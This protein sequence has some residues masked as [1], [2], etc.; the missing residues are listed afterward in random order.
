MRNIMVEKSYTKC[1][2]E[3]F[4]RLLPKKPKLNILLNQ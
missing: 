4:S 2:G 1:G 3:T